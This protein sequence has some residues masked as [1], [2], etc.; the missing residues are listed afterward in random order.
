MTSKNLRTQVSYKND[1]RDYKIY[2]YLQTKRDKSSYI[3]DLI[4]ADMLKEQNK[5]SQYISDIVPQEKIT[6][7]M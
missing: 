4:E 6:M 3:K 1:E 2:E 5:K 7:D